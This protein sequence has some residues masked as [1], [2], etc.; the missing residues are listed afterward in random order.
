MSDRALSRLMDRL[1]EIDRTAPRFT[2]R[3]QMVEVIE[4]YMT[5][6]TGGR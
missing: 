5:N 1:D 3:A 4:D 2:R 6:L